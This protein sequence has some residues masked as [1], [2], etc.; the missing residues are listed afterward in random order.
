MIRVSPDGTA[1]TRLS[2][3]GF[4]NTL[5]QYD[6]GTDLPT[7]A[8][9]FHHIPDVEVA[10]WL[11]GIRQLNGEPWER[12]GYVGSWEEAKRDRIQWVNGE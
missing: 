2:G 3:L 9:T 10:V 8:F 1:R 6:D 7:Y 11:F 5:A 4:S 12:G